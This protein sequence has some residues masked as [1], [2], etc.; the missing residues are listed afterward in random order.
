MYGEFYKLV[1][2][3]PQ[4][5]RGYKNRVAQLGLDEAIINQFRNRH[6][7][8]SDKSLNSAKNAGRLN[9]IRCRYFHALHNLQNGRGAEV[10]LLRLVRAV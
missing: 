7:G 4:L 9:R 6:K 2:D 10:C 5:P 8:I 1:C 3:V